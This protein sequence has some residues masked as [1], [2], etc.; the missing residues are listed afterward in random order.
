LELAMRR[1]V[2]V[3]RERLRALTARP[4]LTRPLELVEMQRQRLDD[5]SERLNRASGDRVRD[6]RH[7]V[8]FLCGRL[9][10]L[11]PL[12]VMG[13]GYAAVEKLPERRVIRAAQEAAPGDPLAIRFHDGTIVTRVEAIEPNEEID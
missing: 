4:C 13:R 3:E 12:R 5:L 10:A 8:A 1:H 6:A 11:S 7:R 9:D 2:A